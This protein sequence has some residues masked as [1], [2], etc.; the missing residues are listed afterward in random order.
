MHV[1]FFPRP[2]ASPGDQDKP[3]S[4]EIAGEHA[5]HLGST[6]FQQI[7]NFCCPPWSNYSAPTGKIPPVFSDGSRNLLF[8]AY[9]SIS[10]TSMYEGSNVPAY[11]MDL[12]TSGHPSQG[13]VTACSEGEQSSLFLLPTDPQISQQLQEK[14]APLQPNIPYLSS[15][16]P[17]SHEPMSYQS[18]NPQREN[19]KKETSPTLIKT[20]V[21]EHKY[22]CVDQRISSSTSLS[23]AT[24]HTT[25][26]ITN[27]RPIS[28]DAHDLARYPAPDQESLGYHQS[29]SPQQGGP[30]TD[31][32]PVFMK[33]EV[34]K[35][36]YQAVDC[37]T[38]PDASLNAIADYTTALMTKDSSYHT[39]DLA[40]YP[41]PQRYPMS[42][43]YGH[44]G[45][46]Q[47]EHASFFQLDSQGNQ[48]DM[49]LTTQKPQATKRGPFKDPKKREKT[50][51]VRKVGSC[52]RCRMQRIRVSVIVVPFI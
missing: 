42:H 51:Q 49:V 29:F 17:T 32:S 26:E 35:Y 30:K 21:P 1:P 7:E 24:N 18:F 46:I 27:S 38:G 36:E 13:Q 3:P 25:A 6:I 5:D 8:Q 31:H 19:F 12:A 41:A 48:L 2:A 20:E 28:Y 45:N 4:S 43:N 23:V 14:F 44:E 11:S 10:S 39:H 16:P 22:Q 9:M 47:T 52:I 40:R 33:P 15:L 50:A 34:P 37:R